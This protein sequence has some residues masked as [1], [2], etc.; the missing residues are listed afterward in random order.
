MTYLGAIVLGLVEGATEFIP[1]SSSGHLIIA[2]RF[3]GIDSGGLSFD[4]ILQLATTLA[5]LIYFWKDIG[6]LIITFK[7][8]I[9]KEVVEQKEKILFYAVLFGTIPAVI[10]GL[11]LEKDM[12]TIFRN[13]YL[14]AAT[15]FLGSLLMW[16]AQKKGREDKT[17]TVKKGIA[18][19]FYQCLALIPGVSR[20]GATISGGLFSGLTREEATRFS[21][22]LSAPILVGAGLKKLLEVRHEIFS[23]GFGF[24]LLVGSIVAFVTGLIA[25]KFLITYLKNHNLNIFIWYRI[26]MALLLVILL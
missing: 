16:F 24:P 2:R 3:L 8:I 18:I 5:I 6:G 12:D 11:L 1:V 26:I 25:I 7:K 14:V 10:F 23:S 22:V 4:A 13:V 17:L 19:G 20:S 21:F 15:L 9:F